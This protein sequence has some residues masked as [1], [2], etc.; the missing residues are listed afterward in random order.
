[1]GQMLVEA[2]KVEGNLARAGRMIQ[3]AAARDCKIII[4]PECL[5]IGWT[6]PQAKQLAEP[7]PGATSDRLAA[8]AKETGI[9]V[10]AG[11]TEKAGEKIY[12]TALLISPAGEILLKHRKINVLD[13]AQDVYAI[14]DR[15]GVADTEIGRIGIDICADNFPTSLVFGHSLARMGAD[16]ILSPSAWAVV[17]EH[18]NEKEPYGAE[19]VESYTTLGRLY[20]ITIVGVSNVG[21]ITAGP[22]Q[23]R[24]C[25]G[26]S[27]AVGPGGK[28]LAKGD[29][30]AGAE[31]LIVIEIQIASAKKTGTDI[32]PMLHEKGYQGP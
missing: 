11:I 24:R 5:D 9:Y 6:H 23:G 17:A 29:Y 31:Q 14:G 10:V 15:L 1:M 7:V 27:L 32:A 18:D 30:G 2:G 21:A 8:A 25:I 16:M 4:L 12:N 22:W 26:C 19:W 3:E 28:I 13:I 20:D